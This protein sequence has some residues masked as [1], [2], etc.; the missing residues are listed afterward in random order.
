MAV[1]VVVIAQPVTDPPETPPSTQVRVQVT[2]RWQP[3]DG[4]TP[5]AAAA[6]TFALSYGALEPTTTASRSLAQAMALIGIT[7]QVAP[8]RQ[9][10]LNQQAILEMSSLPPMSSDE[11][12]PLN[13]YALES[14]AGVDAE[15]WAAHNYTAAEAGPWARARFDARSALEWL[16]TDFTIDEALPWRE[17]GFDVAEAGH[18]LELGIDV[19]KFLELEASGIDPSDYASMAAGAVP[20][21][22]MGAWLDA[23]ADLD[24]L[25]AGDA[26][27]FVDAGITPEQLWGAPPNLTARQIVR[28]ITDGDDPEAD[29]EGDDPWDEDLDPWDEDPDPASEDDADHQS[30]WY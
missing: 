3:S 30:T 7:A 21:E 12:S 29:D 22:E 13:P 4:S 10:H 11:A 15:V 27:V 14:V 9:L 28:F 16:S 6:E 26:A 24:L 20:E 25:E 17:A 23:I 1:W 2:T 8:S 19:D 18:W 5:D